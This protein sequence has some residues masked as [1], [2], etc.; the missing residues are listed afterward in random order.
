MDRIIYLNSNEE[1]ALRLLADGKSLYTL[2]E[3]CVIP[4]AGMAMFLQSLRHK[5]GIRDTRF[6]LEC[7][8]YLSRYATAMENP[9]V[10]DDEKL[11]L[12]LYAGGETH[13]GIASVVKMEEAELTRTLQSLLE[14]IG[15]FSKDDRICR[16]QARVYLITFRLHL[17]PETPQQWEVLRLTADGLNVKEIAERLKLPV[18]YAQFKLREVCARLR[19]LA[20]GRDVQRN[21]IRAY[22][23]SHPQ[24]EPQAE[25]PEP[26]PASVPTMADPMF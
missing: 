15:I 2:R 5:T 8:Q 21:L 23:A 10:T 13:M 19:L 12:Q 11:I 20:R 3:Q 14:R 7:R 9:A 26:S 18:E 24:P 25:Q 17:L 16:F 1:M 4:L 22:L 6:P